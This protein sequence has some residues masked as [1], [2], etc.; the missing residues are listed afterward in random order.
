MNK[1]VTR[2]AVV[3]IWVTSFILGFADFPIA[4]A[5]Y[6]TNH[7]EPTTT[8]NAEFSFPGGGSGSAQYD[9]TAAFAE[10][11]KGSL[12]S[13]NMFDHVN[14]SLVSESQNPMLRQPTFAKGVDLPLG[15]AGG[16]DQFDGTQNPMFSF[17][18]SNGIVPEDIFA[19]IQSG[20]NIP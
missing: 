18:N 6:L 2:I 20:N 11:T 10:L 12:N 4:T 3:A 1:R 19:G 17:D 13:N 7:Y 5:V 16:F 14:V 8:S 9:W 15:G